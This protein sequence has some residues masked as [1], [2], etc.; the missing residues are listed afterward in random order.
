M[1][2]FDELIDSRKQWIADVL[3]PWCQQASRMELLKAE[4]EWTDIAG[5]AGVEFTLWPWAWSRF[6][7]LY[8]E[9][10]Q[11]ID[12]TYRVTVQLL[13]GQEI[14]GYPDNRRSERGQLVLLTTTGEAGPFALDTIASVTRTAS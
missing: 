5:R 8:V 7:V 1:S 13:N 3:R 6:P 9:G 11:G 4:R 14:T 2:T 12:E 10:L